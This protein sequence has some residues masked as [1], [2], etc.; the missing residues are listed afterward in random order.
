M[1]YKDVIP[2]G[3]IGN[4]VISM[5]KDDTGSPIEAF[6]DDEKEETA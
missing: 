4:L 1:F 2:E 6:G 5:M 3:L